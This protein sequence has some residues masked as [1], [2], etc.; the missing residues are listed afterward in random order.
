MPLERVISFAEGAPAPLPIRSARLG[1]LM[2]ALAGTADAR[3]TFPHIKTQPP[4]GAA[5][6]CFTNALAAPYLFFAA[7]MIAST[8]MISITMIM[9]MPLTFALCPFLGSIPTTP[10]HENRRVMPLPT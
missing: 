3:R 1:D 9:T 4:N 7:P 5:L 10:M 8:E 2:P 6:I